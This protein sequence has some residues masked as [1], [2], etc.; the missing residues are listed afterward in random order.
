[1]CAIQ[2][3]NLALLVYAQDDRLLG[4]IQVQPHHIGHLFQKLRIARELKS[5]RAMWLQVMGT[6]DIVDGRLADTLAL[7]HGP[8]TPVR[9]P[10]RFGLQS[11]IHDRGNLVDLIDGFSSSTGSDVPQPVE[12]FVIKA[13]SPQDHGISIHRKPLGN[14][15]I[16][17]ARS[18]GQN[19]TATQSDL[20]GSAVRCN[21]LLEFLLLDF[22]KLASLP[23]TPA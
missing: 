18:G 2:C 9:H 8:A 21:P 17:L 1:M 6:P 14:G 7:R 22:G 23:H 5:L 15:D 12:S 11:R 13:L 16:G 10:R 3:L 20:L 19:D 4:R